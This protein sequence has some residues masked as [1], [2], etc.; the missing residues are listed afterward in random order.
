MFSLALLFLSSAGIAHNPP[1]DAAQVAQEVL[2]SDFGTA[3]VDCQR[4]AGGGC[5]PLQ[6]SSPQRGFHGQ[7]LFGRGPFYLSHLP[8]YAPPHNFQ[9]IYEVEFSADAAGEA[10]KER[11]LKKTGG[12]RYATF[13][14][15]R[16]PQNPAQNS[17]SY[18]IPEVNCHAV[19]GSER[20]VLYGT[21]YAGH[22]ERPEQKPEALGFGGFRV[23]R[24]VYY[25]ELNPNDPRGESADPQ[26]PGEYIVFGEKDQFF[27]ARVLGKRPGVDHILPVPA[28]LAAGFRRDLAGRPHQRYQ[29]RI[30][31][32]KKLELSREAK[33]TQLPFEEFYL[34]TEELR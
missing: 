27:A 30:N 13:A 28:A 21:S 29:A 33:T 16:N 23:K 18:V 12:A 11:Y 31:S 14:P 8:M 26:A 25:K 1:L 9:A 34:E 7:L 10:L 2:A 5:E 17:S 24:V 20:P 6:Y 32:D 15:G 22:F 3:G 19:S 4:S